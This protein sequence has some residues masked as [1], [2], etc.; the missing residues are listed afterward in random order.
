MI[1]NYSGWNEPF[2][3]CS[4]DGTLL[5]DNLRFEVTE[6]FLTETYRLLKF[7]RLVDLRA[8]NLQRQGRLGTYAPC[9]GQEGCQVG[10]VQGL[11]EADP[12]FPTY[13][14]TAAMITRGIPLEKI[15]QYWSGDERGS[16]WSRDRNV[17]PMS[18]PVGS[19]GLHG[20]GASY[21]L[22]YRGEDRLSVVF[23]GD[24]ATSEG[25]MLEAMNFAGVWKTPVLFFCQNNQWAI[26]VP[27][28]KQTASETLAQKA[29]AFG[30][31]GVRLDGNDPLAS[32]QMARELREYAIE[33]SDPV[34]VEA[35]TY[36]YGDH[37]T[38]D[39][40]SRY[41][42]EGER[43]EWMNKD[44]LT[45]T[46]RLLET[47]YGWDDS[48]E[49]SLEEKLNERIDEAIEAFEGEPDPDPSSMFEYLY[50]SVPDRLDEQR[51]QLEDEL[52][53]D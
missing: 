1:E 50:E 7:S 6:D 10:L 51:R 52:E 5:E 47:T 35:V 20:V 29:E 43:E 30:F 37:T 34:F 18:I 42:D 40:A 25:D 2:Q 8:V 44:P 24:G 22:Q 23:L 38:S 31:S 41:R 27:R 53:D 4:P 12:L 15:Y 17:F 33:E 45:R 28:K 19:Q 9:Q 3:V 21:A 14:E 36:R 11:E 26:S 48:R 13:R 16:T 49:E 46:R 32:Y 39:D